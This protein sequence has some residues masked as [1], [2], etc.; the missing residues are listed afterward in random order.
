MS[1]VLVIK[2]Y[3]QE[4]QSEIEKNLFL[5]KIAANSLDDFIN[6]DKRV[7]EELASLH[8]IQEGR[9]TEANG[10][11]QNFA[12]AHPE[13][14]SF[15][16][17]QKDGNVIAQYPE[18]NGYANLNDQDYQPF[19][20]GKMPVDGPYREKASGKEVIIFTKPYY[21]EREEAGIVGMA[22]RLSEFQEKL[23]KLE[24]GQSGYFTLLNGDDGQVLIHP[25]LEQYRDTFSFEDSPF[26]QEIK[27]NKLTSGHFENE[28][29][30][31]M[32]TFT[33]LKET[34][35]VVVFAQPMVEF[36]LRTYHNREQNLI[37]LVLLLLFMVLVIH[38]LFTLRDIK[39]A[40][41]NKQT[42]K[43]ALIGELA[44]GIAHEI[45]NPL[46]SIKGFTQL[47]YEKKGQDLPSFYYET[48]LEELD[49]IDEIVGEMVVLAKPA[50]DTKKDVDLSKVLQD[51]VNLMSYQAYRCGVDVVL[52]LEPSLPLVKGISGQLKQVFINLI[53]NAIEAIE[54]N[55]TITI[56]AR[57]Q[58]S[59][60]LITIE[61][62]GPGMD[63]R[64]IDKLG[65]P[66]FS[67]K[68]KGTG[69]GLMITFRIIQN[70]KGK[71]SVNSKLGVGSQFFISLPVSS[72][73]K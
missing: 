50:P 13:A 57:R 55:G 17:V 51:S 28:Q 41:K 27:L 53:K 6:S 5:T 49:R 69:L 1:Y 43:L 40:E 46:T 54:N 63:I 47:I 48:I 24:T 42:E 45:R 72:T 18:N 64:L 65:T 8:D 10:I 20:K 21:H 52:N 68:E 59:R 36:N 56:E 4:K 35:W 67:T 31:K 3:N 73:V 16:V 14:S 9:R 2:Q 11:L 33:T 60:V 25:Y 37:I 34:P 32:H 26:Y 39:N 58:E 70:H 61:D 22:I 66:F 15:W 19:I 30:Q 12:R 7:L 38:Y 23:A 71:V 44:A 29:E 62:T